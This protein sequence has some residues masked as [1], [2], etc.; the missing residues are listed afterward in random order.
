[1]AS[2]ARAGCGSEITCCTAS[3]EDESAGCEGHSE[4]LCVAQDSPY[5]ESAQAPRAG[6]YKPPG[7]GLS[8][9]SKVVGFSIL[10]TDMDLISRGVRKSKST[11]AMAEAT[12]WEMFMMLDVEGTMPSRGTAQGVDQS[13]PSMCPRSFRQGRGACSAVRTGRQAICC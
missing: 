7:M 1:M 13:C 8:R 6:S 2:V 3:R 10:L 12:G 4:Q 5:R 9:V 11:A